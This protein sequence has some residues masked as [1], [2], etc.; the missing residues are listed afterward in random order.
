MIRNQPPEITLADPV[1]SRE[2]ELL[3]RT[4][5]LERLGYTAVDPDEECL[6]VKVTSTDPD[7]P[8]GIIDTVLPCG[9]FTFPVKLTP[10]IPVAGTPMTLIKQ[11]SHI[12]F[13]VVDEN[14][15]SDTVTDTLITTFNQHPGDRVHPARTREHYVFTPR[16]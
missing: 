12:R 6:R 13:E 7:S 3:R 16:R 8:A 4:L 11:Y 15:E 1:Q 9:P 10:R 5:L 14:G 2:G